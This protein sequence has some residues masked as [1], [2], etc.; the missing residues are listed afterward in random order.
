VKP[1]PFLRGNVF[2][3]AGGVPY[4]RA[5]ADDRLP[6]DTWAMAQHP[7]GVRLELVG[8]AT[9]VEVAYRTETPATYRP[10]AGSTWAAWQG[11][12]QL[13]EVPAVVGTGSARIPL[14]RAAAAAPITVYLPDGMRPTVL[15]VGASG[16][17]LMPAPAGPRWICYGD[18]I[19]EGWV[20]SSPGR[21]WAAIAA[22]RWQLDVANLS[23]AG[24]A[25]GEIVS[26][27]HIASLPADVISI[28]YGTNCWTRVP[29]SVEMMTAGLD[30][31]LRVIRA[32]HP[33][34]PILVVSPVV[35]P[36]AESTPNALGADLRALREAMERTTQSRIAAGDGS[37]ELVPGYD[38]L[39]PEH[40]ADGIHPNDAGHEIMAAVI[41]PRIAAACARR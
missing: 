35:R 10:A 9:E 34:V 22:R 31:F 17:T 13:A 21:T 20:A 11:D 7:V 26:A 8:D 5:R 1:D 16:G 40:L 33:V 32:A 39:R 18:S 14:D 23:Y 30:A 15:E 19:A 29:F 38:I 6:A 37:L 12:R 27:E 2:P 3:P 25:R 4:P 36:S 28:S 24:A 41:G